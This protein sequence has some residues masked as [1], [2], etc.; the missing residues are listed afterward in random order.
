MIL[1]VQRSALRGSVPIPGSKSHTVRAVVL[2]S[3]AE[4]RSRLGDPLDSLDTRAAVGACS[5]LGAKIDTASDPNA[6]FIEGVAGKPSVP[7]NVID[8]AN[9][10]TTLYVV[11]G[12]AALCGSGWVVLTGDEQ[13]R[14][15]P[16]DRLMSALRDLGVE[17]FST[18]G[19]DM[20][21]FVLRGPLRGGR[22]SIEAIT[23]QWVTSILLN[24][25]LAQRDVELE[26][27]R[28]N[29]APYVQMTV[30]WLE[31]LGIEL[32]YDEYFSRFRIPSG[33]HYPSFDRAIPADFSSATFF[34]VAGAALDAELELTGLDMRD[35]QGD[36]AVIDY[37][38]AMGAKIEIDDVAGAIRVK[39]SSL[40]GTEIDLNATP[41][42]LPA[43]AV[44][45]A[46]ADGI[47]TL[48]NVPQAR[49]KET[50]R[51][52]VMAAELRKMGVKVK[53]TPDGMMIE[54]RNGT[55][56]R[57][58][59]LC[60]HGDHRVVMALSLAAMAAEGPSRIDTAESVAVTFPSFVSLMT[61]LGARI[62]CRP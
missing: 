34:L 58:E 49:V 19:N 21:P 4:G 25:P 59:S 37:L 56:E 41:D 2:A 43:M 62:E 39:K 30:D 50:D 23:S 29:E 1:E 24:A 46:L 61:N 12:A 9:S 47:T 53:E 33:Q 44:A 11:M 26:V 15:R 51:I 48:V 17:I 20:C 28:L 14:R 6:W 55:L 16:A 57:C 38:K 22:T 10:G 8:V 35:S 54:G 52:A 45:G 3:L 31:G 7:E 42:A 18:R 40:H 36:K 27:T 32:E 60:G 5:A 13:I